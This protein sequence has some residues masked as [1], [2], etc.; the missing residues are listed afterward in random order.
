MMPWFKLIKDKMTKLM[1]HKIKLFYRLEIIYQNP[2]VM[3]IILGLPGCD[4]AC[5]FI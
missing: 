4:L 5:N 3:S 1:E 2:V